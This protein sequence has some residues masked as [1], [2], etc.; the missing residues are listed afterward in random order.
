M[1]AYP[2]S[3]G[4]AYSG[5]FIS[6]TTQIQGRESK[7]LSRFTRMKFDDFNEKLDY[8]HIDPNLVVLGKIRLP[9]ATYLISVFIK[10]NKETS[11]NSPK[12]QTSQNV[13]STFYTD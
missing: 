13:S 2:D 8:C 10:T 5:K 7:N 12:I 1:N 11:M 4:T 6:N 3:T 9:Q